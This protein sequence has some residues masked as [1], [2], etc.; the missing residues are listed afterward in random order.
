MLRYE[1]ATGKW[2]SPS[3]HLIKA[4]ETI[5]RLNNIMKNET[6]T[7]EERDLAT[8]L[9]QDLQNAVDFYNQVES[10]VNATSTGFAVI[11]KTPW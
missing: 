3:G 10:S 2:L 6:L 5:T 4:V 9:V 8:L 11:Q 7:N 1:A